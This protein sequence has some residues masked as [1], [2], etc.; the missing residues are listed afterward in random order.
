M[1]TENNTPEPVAQ[2]QHQSEVI[3]AA[4]QPPDHLPPQLQE[5]VDRLVAANE[6]KAI[7]FGI[8]P[9]LMKLPSEDAVLVAQAAWSNVT[10]YS[11]RRGIL[12]AF[13][14]ATHPQ[15]VAIMHLGMTDQH[16]EVRETAEFYLRTIALRS[17]KGDMAGYEKWYAEFGDQPLP[18]IFEAG[19]QQLAR[20]LEGVEAEVGR[21][22]LKDLN[23]DFG[24]SNRKSS[25]KE[26]RFQRS[27][28]RRPFVDL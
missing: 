3:L 12:K 11:A 10:D 24:G 14:F 4:P 13:Q 7:A 27:R 23:D 28:S 15:V 8:S 26:K 6:H 1:P 22:I 16:E 21:K 20:T 9:D 17:F 19:Y 5:W 18:K 25:Y 2:Q